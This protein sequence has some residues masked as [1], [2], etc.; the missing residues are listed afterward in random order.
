MKIMVIKKTGL[1][2]LFFVECIHHCIT[3]S[4]SVIWWRAIFRKKYHFY[5]SE[6][7]YFLGCKWS[8]LLN[9]I[10]PFGKLIWYI[11]I[12]QVSNTSDDIGV[13]LAFLIFRNI[14]WTS[15]IKNYWFCFCWWY[16]NTCS[17]RSTWYSSKK[18]E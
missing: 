13:R 9:V 18:Y 7:V 2:D 5:F 1:I 12:I 3:N 15:N 6:F 11:C 16:R 14:V 10:R 8:H 17:S 4:K